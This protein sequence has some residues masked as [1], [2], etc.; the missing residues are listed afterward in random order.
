MGLT[1][2]TTTAATTNETSAT[3]SARSFGRRATDGGSGAEYRRSNDSDGRGSP[4]PR[5]SLPR[6]PHAS[7]VKVVK[8]PVIDQPLSGTIC[9]PLV[10]TGGGARPARHGSVGGLGAAA[11]GAG[12]HL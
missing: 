2:N 12:T 1:K 4:T 6:R 7:S 11:T 5:S 9:Q 3:N 8:H 10:V